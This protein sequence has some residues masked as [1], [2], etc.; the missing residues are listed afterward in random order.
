MKEV[1]IIGGGFGG[2]SAIAKL[3]KA[4]KKGIVHVTLIDKN[5][6]SLFTP[7]LPEVVSG[8]VK[9]ESIV[10]SLREI[11]KKNSA[12][13]NIASV[14]S[15][16]KENKKVICNTHE[17]KYDYLIVAAGSETNFRGNDS[18]ME[19]SLEYKGISDAINLKYRVI[20]LL[21]RAVESKTK[22]E[23]QQLLSFAIIGGGITG[24]E[25]ACELQEFI[26]QRI[27]KEYTGIS[28]DE[29]SINIFEYS[30]TILPAI[31]TNQAIK[32][33]EIVQKKGIKIISHAMVD[34]I[35]PES[36]IYQINTKTKEMLTST[37]IWT[38]GVKGQNF[39]KS[40]SPNVTQDGRIPITEE[41]RPKE[42]DVDNIF[43]IGDCSAY[44]F[45]DKTLPPVAP[46]AMQQG[47]IAVKNILN[48]MKGKSPVTFSYLNFGYLV[49]LGKNNSVVNLFGLKF[50]GRFA[51][52]AWKMTYLFKIGMLKKQIAVFFDWI[53]AHFFGHD[54]TLI[55]KQENC[56][57]C[58]SC[59]EK[60][61]VG[62]LKKVNDRVVKT[63]PSACINCAT[64]VAVCKYD[65]HRTLTV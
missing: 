62:I 40:I 48:H 44:S 2:L 54:A 29:F 27:E 25:L 58:N 52:F 43:V 39:L 22:E 64:C 30:D 57:G 12:D 47:P 28:P 8:T 55:M 56:V 53:L 65:V 51:Y 46:L 45:K 41:L 4:T 18:A 26:E 21:E 59:I 60:C 15:I 37:I 38:A 36:I 10:F 33:Q 13:F 11:C 34:E 50:R 14:I 35:L 42:L 19:N 7:M 61:P 16:D 63:D 32:A 5:N 31:D 1:V 6:F 49:A 3:K 23:R 20:Q 17:V 9:P 24:V